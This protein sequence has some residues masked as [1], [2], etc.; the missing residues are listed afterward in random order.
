MEI[1]TINNSKNVKIDNI[2]NKVI[3]KY[4]KDKKSKRTFIS[5]LHH[6]MNPEEIKKF[7][8][9][10]TK[11]LGAGMCTK[12]TDDGSFEYGFQGDH[13]EKIQTFLIENK[14]PKEAIF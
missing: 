5:G 7:I 8:V 9:V 11:K 6:F 10:L 1:L 4:L 3:V 12:E 13:I 2:N 14:I